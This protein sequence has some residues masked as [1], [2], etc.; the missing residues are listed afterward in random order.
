MYKTNSAIRLK[1]V[2]SKAYKNNSNTIKDV[3]KEVFQ[4]DLKDSYEIEK[5]V[6]TCLDSLNDEFKLFKHNMERTTFSATLYEK[7]IFHLQKLLIVP[8][9]I[10]GDWKQKKS[11]I[12]D[13][14]FKILDFCSEILPTDEEEIDVKDIEELKKLLYEL[15]NFVEGNSL[16]TDL[17]TIIKKH[18]YKIK[19]ALYTFSV[20][21]SIV[22]DE[23]LKSAYGEVINNPDIF[24]DKSNDEIKI[25]LSKLW[26]SVQ[27]IHSVGKK[28][29]QYYIDFNNFTDA[30]QNLLPSGSSI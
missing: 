14:H 20:K 18:I 27:K 25:K 12:T 22:F 13:V 9:G 10:N 24:K 28:V 6:M 4:I 11:Q 15:E 8:T 17:N 19:V 7:E 2:I 1:N 29:E 16:P 26:S 3:W 21:G 5:T 30:V 23:V